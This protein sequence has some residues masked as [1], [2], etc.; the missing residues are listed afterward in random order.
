VPSTILSKFIIFTSHIKC[1]LLIKFT[2]VTISENVK[3][4]FCTHLCE[5][6]EWLIFSLYFL[7]GFFKYVFLSPLSTIVQLDRSGQFYWWRKPEYP[8]QT[9]DPSQVIDKHYYII[10]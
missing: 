10:L 1:Q 6:L 9:T 7:N 5:H 3:L 8:E 4:L 2:Y